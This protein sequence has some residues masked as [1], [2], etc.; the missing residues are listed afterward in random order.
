MTHRANIGREAF[1]EFEKIIKQLNLTPMQLITEMFDYIIIRFVNHQNIPIEYLNNIIANC[2][3]TIKL[4]K[5]T[6]K[7]PS[8]STYSLPAPETK[9]PQT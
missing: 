5:Q 4:I 1:D 8:S 6:T 2:E 3:H 7:L 9:H